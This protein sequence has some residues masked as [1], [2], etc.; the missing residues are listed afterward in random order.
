MK[1]AKRERPTSFEKQLDAEGPMCG[2]GTGFHAMANKPARKRKGATGGRPLSKRITP[3]RTTYTETELALL[4]RVAC[5][6]DESL[7]LAHGI[8]GGALDSIQVAVCNCRNGQNCSPMD[9]LRECADL[10]IQQYEKL[11]GPLRRVK[12][13]LG[14]LDH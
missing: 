7:S 1:V 4:D 9:T 8:T 5:S 10:A 12:R 11:G 3:E 6:L 14:G 2:P 13:I